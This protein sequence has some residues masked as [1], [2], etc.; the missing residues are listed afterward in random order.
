MDMVLEHFKKVDANK[1]IKCFQDYMKHKKIAVTRAQYEANLAEKLVSKI[2]L[3]DIVP[4][5]APGS[6]EFNTVKAGERFKNRFLSL[7]PGKPW[8]GKT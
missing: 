6:P 7:L 2:F 4:L 5:L 8:K 3:Q 1:V